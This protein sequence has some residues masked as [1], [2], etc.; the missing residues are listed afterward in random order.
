MGKKKKGNTVSAS[1]W[2]HKNPKKFA[3][4]RER[5]GVE[6]AY[7]GKPSAYGG[8]DDQPRSKE[9]VYND[10]M[11]AARNDYDTRRGIEAAAMSGHKKSEKLAKGGFNN[12]K[13]VAKA[14]NVLARLKKKHVGGGGMSGAKNIMGLT[15]ALV[16]H[17]REVQD[18][19][20]RREFASIKDMNALR[21]DLESQ[22]E[23]S[24][25]NPAPIE[26]SDA[27]ARAEERVNEADHGP[28]S[29][30]SSNNADAATDNPPADA[31]KAF[32]YDYRE[33]VKEKFAPSPRADRRRHAR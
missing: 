17:D 4:L 10:I 31:S 28:G 13:D 2:G 8:T 30:Y 3:E 15:H 23:A 21:D 32:L 24:N 25:H 16:E 19:G 33:K 5:Y 14:N 9:D 1:L 20:Y 18:E 22:E 7:G 11:A 29:I 26:K 27:L 12:I 6:G